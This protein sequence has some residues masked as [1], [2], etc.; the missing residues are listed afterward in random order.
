MG[1]DDGAMNASTLFAARV[2]PA[3]RG[4][5]A[6]V[7]LRGQLDVVDA[8]PA[9]FRAAN[10]LPVSRQPAGRVCFGRW[11][12]AESEDVIVCRVDEST[13]DVHCHGGDAAA[14]RI[15][16]D[17]AGRGCRVLTWQ[18]FVERTDGLLAAELLQTLSR[19]STL[20]TA[21]LLLEQQ[22]GVLRSAFE[23]LLTADAISQRTGV[24]AMLAWAEF[25][26]H[27]S[28]PW[29]VVLFGRPNVGKSSLINALVG[30][31]RSIVYDEPG[32]TRDVVTAETAL[33]GWPIRLA[34]TAGIRDE[35][36]PLE[37]SGITL[38]R[39]H[40]ETAD[41]R[42]LLLDISDPP[43]SEDRQLLADSQD[44]IVVAHKCDLS[45]VW[46]AELPAGAIS[47]SS[48]TGTGLDEL[49]RRIVAKLVP[50]LPPTGAAIP[51]TPR[52]VDLLRSALTSLEAGDELGC[53]ASLT[54]L[55]T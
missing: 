23:S 48:K 15:L 16:A 21:G 43:R 4:A 53:R 25:G 36:G 27:L 37:L 24:R 44:A 1:G 13:L 14:G 33:E 30:Y 51:V 31:G 47:V 28:V 19:A 22:S 39:C 52:Q 32:T 54:S 35:A 10:S 29:S 49:A 7:R 5:V 17:L 38:T 18:Q 42:V 20:R 45:N 41:C 6:T 8:E 12:R 55:L 50:E 26:T 3:G 46:G 2:T 9:L 34:D 40:L 11:G